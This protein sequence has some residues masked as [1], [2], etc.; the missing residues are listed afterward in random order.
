MPGRRNARFDLNRSNGQ[1]MIGR[2]MPN[3]SR[4]TTLIQT[5]HAN[6]CSSNLPTYTDPYTGYEVFTADFLRRRGYCCGNGCRHCPYPSG[7]QRSS[8][9][10]GRSAERGIEEAGARHQLDKR[11]YANRIALAQQELYA[12][13]TGRVQE[14]LDDCPAPL[15]GWEWYF[16]ERNT[17]ALEAAE[18]SRFFPTFRKESCMRL[19]RAGMVEI[20]YHLALSGISLWRR[21]DRLVFC[22][23]SARSLA[24]GWPGGRRTRSCWSGS[25]L[26]VARRRTLRSRPRRRLRRWWRGMGRWFWASAGAPWPTRTTLRTP[27]RR[28]F[29]CWYGGLDRSGWET[30]W[31]AGCMAWPDESPPRPRHAPSAPGCGPYRLD[32]NRS[33]RNL[34]PTGSSCWRRLTRKSA[35]CRRSTWRRSS[36]AISRD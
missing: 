28:R 12:Q 2:C 24:R 6:A 15:R 36:S 29:S 7:G 25:C 27:F 16:L 5:L 19:P 9:P 10:E 13:N 18:A 26:G 4:E 20:E 17:I 11:R 23:R 8:L 14:L 31:A 21:R 22:I 35:G 32:T 3:P 30:R 33:P 34:P 1:G